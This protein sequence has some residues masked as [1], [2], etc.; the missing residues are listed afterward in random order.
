MQK[1]KISIVIPVY[2]EEKLIAECLDALINQDYP[3]KDYEIVVVNDGS[4][5]NTLGVLKRKQKEAR[6]KGLKVK[7]V[8]FEINK[9]RVIARRTGAKD[10]KYNNLL[11][12]DSRC[13]ADKKILKNIRNIDYQPIVGNSIIDF[14][15]STFDR[16]NW[17]I[18]K[19][20]YFPYFGERFEPVYITK[21]NF[22]KI[23]KGTGALLCDKKLFLSSQLESRS[24]NISDDTKLLWNIVQKKKIL[25]HP[26]VKVKYLSRTSLKKEIK[27]TFQRGPKFVDYYLTHR[28]RYFW[29][30]IFLPI[31]GLIFTITLIFINLTYF[32]YWLWFLILIWIL[33]SIWLAKNVKD[34]FIAFSFLPIVVL[35]F[36]IGILKGVLLKLVRRY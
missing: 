3:K 7:I 29:L 22:D 26:D 36:E 31:I 5:D 20:I 6:G 13:V 19:K 17:M 14:R 15:R 9:G 21:D 35:I 11:F 23:G 18:R 16:F 10:A 12:I 32:L 2:N 33:I 27:H 4:T 28:K 24:K 30:F 1:M 34:F 25:R 8:N